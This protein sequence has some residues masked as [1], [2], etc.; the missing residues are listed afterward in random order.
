VH[1]AKKNMHFEDFTA[2]SV[3]LMFNN[4]L[5]VYQLPGWQKII[6]SIF[7]HFEENPQK[8]DGAT[9]LPTERMTL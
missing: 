4:I 6:W 7:L 8:C 3:M 9:I 1:Q 2:N 5:A